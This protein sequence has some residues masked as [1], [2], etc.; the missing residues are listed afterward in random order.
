[1]PWTDRVKTQSAVVPYRSVAILNFGPILRHLHILMAV[2]VRQ[3]VTHVLQATI[4]RFATIER[5]CLP[6][7]RMHRRILPD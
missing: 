2:T 4:E 5:H 1:M 6:K 3:S 7:A